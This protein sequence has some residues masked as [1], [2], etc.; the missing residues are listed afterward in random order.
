MS[1]PSWFQGQAIWSG[2][3]PPAKGGLQLDLPEAGAPGLGVR[4]VVGGVGSVASWD[5]W[6]LIKLQTREEKR[7]WGGRGSRYRDGG[8]SATIA[9]SFQADG[10]LPSGELELQTSPGSRGQH[11]GGAG[12]E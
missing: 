2:Y 3:L 5:W 9:P 7:G 4:M 11:L 12:R 10:T 1:V 8:R 6:I